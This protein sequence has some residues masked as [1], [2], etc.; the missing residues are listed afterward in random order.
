MKK[1]KISKI[2]FA[3]TLSLS[4]KI[5]NAD[6]KLTES[7]FTL[8]LD[9]SY[10]GTKILF[11]T[12]KG[13]NFINLVTIS[14]DG[15]NET[16][17]TTEE[18]VEFGLFY[19]DGSIYYFCGSPTDTKLCRVNSDGSGKTTLLTIPS[20]YGY[21]W[22]IEN[23]SISTATAKIAYI[24]TH[25]NEAS[26][27]TVNLDGTNNTQLTNAYPQSYTKIDFSPDGQWIVFCS[28]AGYIYK[29]KIDNTELTQL[30]TFFASYPD[31]SGD[32]SKIA[33][34]YEGDIWTINSDGTG[35]TNLTGDGRTTSDHYPKFS[36][37]GTR[38]VWIR[39][40]GVWVMNSD[41]TDKLK[42]FS[43]PLHNIFYY[44][45]SVW[46]KTGNRIA[47]S[48]L[49]NIYTVSSDGTNLQKVTNNLN[50]VWN[51]APIRGNLLWS[52]DYDKIVYSSWLIDPLE[53]RLSIMNSDG[54]NK[55][56]LVVSTTVSPA[57]GSFAPHKT[58]ILYTKSYEIYSINS[59]GT[60]ET[61]LAYGEDPVWSPDTTKIVFSSA[62][63]L[64]VMNSDG[65]NQ[66]ILAPYR[67]YF[68]FKI[69]WSSDSTKIVYTY[70]S[71][72]WVVSLA[73]GTT[74]QITT[75]GSATYERGP[76]FSPDNTKIAY[77]RE[78]PSELWVMNSDGTNKIK[79]ADA[80]LI[81]IKWA[82][83]NRIYYMNNG[84]LWSINPD[85]TDARKEN[86]VFTWI[87]RF[88]VSPAGDLIYGGLDIFIKQVS[89]YIAGK[90][91][92]SDGVSAIEGA[93]VEVLQDGIVKSSAT[94]DTNG[95]YLILIATGT[96]DVRASADGYVTQIKTGYAVYAGATTTVNFV[97]HVGGIISGKV[98]QS[99]GVTGISEVSIRVMK[100][101]N[102]ISQTVTDVNGGYNISIASG[103]YDVVAS[104]ETGGGN[105]WRIEYSTR[106]NVVVHE[107]QTTENISFLF[108]YA[109]NCWHSISSTEGG[110]FP[111]GMRDPKFPKVNQQINIYLG[112]RLTAENIISATLY[113]K[114]SDETI[115]SSANFVFYSTN[116]TGQYLNNY[117]KAVI[118]AQTSPEVIQYYIKVQYNKHETTFVY[119]DDTHSFTTIREFV[120]QTNPF[121][122]TI[123]GTSG[124]SGKVTDKNNNPIEGVTIYVWTYEP[125]HVVV[126]SAT[127]DA[128]GKYTVTDL[129]A[130]KYR[131]GVSGSWQRGYV[132]RHYNDKPDRYSA[133]PVR[134][135]ESEITENI[136]FILP[137]TCKIS[138]KVKDQ[139]GNDF[140][141]VIVEAI[142][143]N[144]QSWARPRDPQTGEWITTSS[145]GYYQIV[146]L[147]PGK[148]KV[149]AWFGELEKGAKPVYYNNK[150]NWGQADEIE[151]TEGAEVTG[152]DFTIARDISPPNITI[153]INNDA[154]STKIRITTLT[155]SCT[156]D[157]SGVDRVRFSNDNLNWTDW[158]IYSTTTINE[159]SLQWQLTESPG[160]KTVYAQA[161]DNAGNVS[162]SVSDTIEL[163]QEVV[164]PPV[165]VT[166]G[167]NDWWGGQQEAQ[168]DNNTGQ[169]TFNIWSIGDPPPITYTI[170]F[171]YEPDEVKLVLPDGRKLP[172]VKKYQVS[173]PLSG[174]IYIFEVS[175]KDI[176]ETATRISQ[177]E[178]ELEV[179]LEITDNEQTFVQQL[180]KVTLHDPSGYVYNIFNNELI[181]G[182]TVTLYR[183]DIGTGKFEFADPNFVN[184]KPAI[185]P[186][187]TDVRGYY[188]W[189][190]EPGRY[191]VKVEAPWYETTISSIVIIPPPVTDLHIGMKPI[192]VT[193]P[194][195]SV[196]IQEGPYVQ[197]PIVTLKIDVSDT[198]SGLRGV[199][200]SDKPDFSNVSWEA[201]T[202][203]KRFVFDSE[204]GQKTVYVQVKDKNGNILLTSAYTAL[205]A[206]NLNDAHPYP[207]PFKPNS[208]PGHTKIT[209]TE[210][211]QKVRI[212]VFN[213]A[214]EL[215][216][217][218]NEISTDGTYS[219]DVVNQNRQPLASGVYIY[220]I[221]DKNS[222]KTGKL[223]IIR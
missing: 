103:V 102:L 68:G 176:R 106:T 8:L 123:I 26:L 63:Y 78:N 77:L 94:T 88:D 137:K 75:D 83:N 157:L 34:E 57:V 43:P 109:G 159:I 80:A 35:L 29:I 69:S 23:F 155:V 195:G 134:V 140:P 153:K 49:Q 163:V 114:K 217:D 168:L 141:G 201:Y 93:L 24:L 181:P 16:Q 196:V 40:D 205:V 44:H 200:I 74:Q 13:N 100:D 220:L 115:W 42:L 99:D 185:N 111:E 101:G 70:D 15:T 223:V 190:V 79:L 122:F 95:D 139:N 58:K 30:T 73:D 92:K 128:E 90:V 182:A 11:A 12:S 148:Y 161:R 193:P 53:A 105:S 188:G 112:N 27:W 36:P 184:M 119:G 85:G 186:Q 17:V 189:D 120:A 132:D 147:L 41:G 206:A 214:G 84:E 45:H 136:N 98:T 212:R 173:E 117:W 9:W 6:V 64:C 82:K 170:F 28:T 199:R 211:T 60:D 104:V 65:S 118:P 22:G 25:T 150:Q 89:G 59:D 10:D 180:G 172:F 187:V 67:Q 91:T 158:I 3:L 204:K 216:Y 96:Y 146:G 19:L 113:Y 130:G 18:G 222:K 126:S 4:V 160:V 154:Q 209:F 72:I 194:S 31:W 218:T 145:T 143:K 197:S 116:T 156:D 107:N 174:W 165:N 198:Q 33:F 131:V 203:I 125:P 144:W 127:T 164:R 121:S 51:C 169:V 37:D 215:V 110:L 5:L 208:V 50:P 133:D 55:Y 86:Q 152:I 149:R 219:W 20:G 183:F 7:N 39:N 52:G 175:S 54:S 207:N 178:G 47:I 56:N 191:Y 129:P 177:W 151:L 108:E 213:I 71:D 48:T 179:S 202:P 14:P 171:G 192:D 138:G 62:G 61:F 66:Q 2:L 166:V 162:E 97:L 210:L 76:V 87:Y 124:I 167:T 135:K 46:E 142:E 1:N 221:T 38:I 21:T 32:G 81:P